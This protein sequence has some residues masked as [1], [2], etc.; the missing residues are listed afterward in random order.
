MTDG[1]IS[2]G[3]LWICGHV[4]AA[5]EEFRTAERLA[6]EWPVPL[7]SLGNIYEGG[8]SLPKF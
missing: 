2:T 3:N 8:G 6:P 5:L 4:N 1:R 7:R